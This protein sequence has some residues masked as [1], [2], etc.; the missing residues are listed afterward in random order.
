MDTMNFPEIFSNKDVALSVASNL[1]I[2]VIILNIVFASIIG[3]F[4]A[5]IYRYFFA[6]VLF[7]KSFAIAIVGT[8][9]I[10]ALVIMVISGNLLLSLG[11]VGA[12]SIVRFRAAI[13]DPLDV[14]YIFWAVGSGIASGVSQYTIAIIGLIMISIIFIILSKV[15]LTDKPK[16]I[17]ISSNISAQKNIEDYISHL[18][19]K[20]VLRSTQMTEGK[21]ELVF[22]TSSNIN[23]NDIID[24]LVKFDKNVELRFLN[25]YGN[26]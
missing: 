12:L 17:V 16:L 10:T 7:Q 9:I 18:G 24:K 26:N 1:T 14:V 19:K 22:E 3:V 6:G 5:I 23:T 21:I 11:M 13:K 20:I 8:T 25:Y 2:S 4:I 15:D